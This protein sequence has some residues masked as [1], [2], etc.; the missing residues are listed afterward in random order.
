MKRLLSILLTVLM[1]LTLVPTSVFAED[2]FSYY[3]SNA[4]ERYSRN[5]ALEGFTFYSAADET[6]YDVTIRGETILV[7]DTKTGKVLTANFSTIDEKTSMG[8]S[9]NDGTSLMRANDYDVWPSYYTTIGQTEVTFNDIAEWTKSAIL[10]ALV[11]AVTA[12]LSAGLA[13]AA[14]FLVSLQG[15]SDIIYRRKYEGTILKQHVMFN[16]YCTTL[17]RYKYDY[18]TEDGIYIDGYFDEKWLLDPYDPNSVYACKVLAG[19]Y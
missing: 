4:E 15:L 8:S 12:G 5:G 19:M 13:V 2:S 10:S 16:V 11:S 6:S 14:G 1:V 9:A 17:A 3:I 18:W 7:K